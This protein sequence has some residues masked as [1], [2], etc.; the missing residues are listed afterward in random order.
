M[1]FTFEWTTIVPPHDKM[2]RENK[3]PPYE[4]LIFGELYLVVHLLMF[5]MFINKLA[6]KKFQ[7]A[8]KF[9]LGF[10]K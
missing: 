10:L 1:Q 6:Y 4:F 3:W 2:E 5:T 9:M 8:P 7:L